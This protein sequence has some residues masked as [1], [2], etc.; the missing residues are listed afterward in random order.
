[1]AEQKP[2][3]QSAYTNVDAT[4]HASTD[5]SL[6]NALKRKGVRNPHQ[7]LS[8][9]WFVVGAVVTICI[10]S[11]LFATFTDGDHAQQAKTTTSA[12]QTITVGLK[13]APVNLDIR[14]QAGS[15]LEQL[16]IGNVYEG[17]VQRDEHNKVRPLLAESW[18][19]SQDARTYTFHLRKGAMFSNGHP[20][21][22]Q[23]AQW[24]LQQLVEHR[25]H[26][27]EMLG[28]I[29]SID[30]PDETTLV[31]KLA[32]PN[33]SFLWALSSR[34]G[35]VFDKRAKFDM[36]TQAIGSGPYLVERFV[37]QDRVILV[38]NT[39]YK[40][41]NP[42]ATT[43][44]VVR[45]ISDDNAGID[46][47][48]SGSVQALLPVATQLA[49][50]FKH[51]NKYVVHAGNS[52]DKFVLAMNAKGA[53]TSDI[54]IRQAIR[55]AINHKEI[56]ASRGGDDLAL[57]G[58]IALLDPGYEDLTNLYPYDVNRARQL[59][60][61]AGFSQAKPLRLTLTYANVYG[62]QLGDQ[63]R[64]QLKSIGIDLQVRQVEFSTWLHDVYTNH[65]YDLSLVDHN[66]SHDFH[67]WANPDY[68]YG[69]Q[70]KK[71]QELYRLANHATDEQTSHR[72][73][74]Q[75]AR[76]VSQ[77]AAADWLFNYRVVSIRSKNLQG[78]PIDMVSQFLPLYRLRITN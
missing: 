13:L 33:A 59:M 6:N 34:P 54:R 60:H 11:A 77:D 12:D 22:A 8:K 45:Y 52:T 14:N 73:L 53:Y 28:K 62:A 24:S 69:Y 23:D 3:K 58:P 40:G 48:S 47:I 66:E 74:A 55:H 44:I 36:K 56:I 4:E 67:Q 38:R 35:L 72:Y 15:A 16:L 75:A 32:E 5:A 41:V 70:S 10:V 71:V 68:Y 31:V 63:L 76:Q 78:M 20:L 7:R 9:W 27:V 2:T 29:A 43:R 57:G 21:T 17:L 37:P 61:E 64:S 39:K 1:M 50:P 18:Q 30:A 26:S 49:E 65:Q 46:A 19:V 25:Y 42:A 51:N